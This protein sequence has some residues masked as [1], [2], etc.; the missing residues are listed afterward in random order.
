[1]LSGA[2]SEQAVTMAEQLRES[3]QITPFP[4]PGGEALTVS[5]GIATATGRNGTC[6]QEALLQRADKALYAAKQAGRNRVAIG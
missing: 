4:V 2:D 6:S 3:V 5:I 1:M